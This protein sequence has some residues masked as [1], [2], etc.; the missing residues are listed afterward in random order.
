VGTPDV[1]RR[2]RAE[3]GISIDHL[4]GVLGVDVRQIRRYETGESQ[5]SLQGARLLARELKITLDELAG[6]DPTFTG[7]WWAHWTG[8]PNSPDQTGPVDLAHQGT[9][10]TVTPATE[11]NLTDVFPWRAELLADPDAL[12]GWYVI[13][14]PD[15]RSRGTLLLE[16]DQHTLGGDWVHLGL[17]GLR[18]G[19]IALARTPEAATKRLQE[20]LDAKSANGT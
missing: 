4:A 18:T 10:V 13:D 7:R 8:L 14:H 15:H 6:G 5:P 9:K 16:F 17:T 11:P 19:S 3:L 2:R 12:F 20:V 1:I